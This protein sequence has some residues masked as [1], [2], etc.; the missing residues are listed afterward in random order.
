VAE[1]PRVFNATV[2]FS[3]SGWIQITPLIILIRVA[4]T[5]ED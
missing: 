5:M 2:G 1:F 4:L 3:L